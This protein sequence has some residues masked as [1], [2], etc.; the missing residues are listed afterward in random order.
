MKHKQR[1]IRRMM[2]A[3]SPE[4]QVLM[5]TD[6]LNWLLKDRTPAEREQKIVFLTPKLIAD[7][8]SGNHGF[9]LLVYHYLKKLLFRRWWKHWSDPVQVSREDQIPR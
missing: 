5:I 7:I 6:F 8:S 3:L 9:W 2:T 4:E 1:L